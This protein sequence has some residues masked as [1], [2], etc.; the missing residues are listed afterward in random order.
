MLMTTKMA[1][2]LYLI[3]IKKE[4]MMINLVEVAI[5]LEDLKAEI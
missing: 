1:F 3:S 4:F 5:F 2:D